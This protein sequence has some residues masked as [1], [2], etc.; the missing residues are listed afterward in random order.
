MLL[1]LE[2][3]EHVV[4]QGKRSCRR[5]TQG[6]GPA[7]RKWLAVDTRPGTV[8][9][10]FETYVQYLK[11]VAVDLHLEKVGGSRFLRG[12]RRRRRDGLGQPHRHGSGLHQGRPDA[13]RPWRRRRIKRATRLRPGGHSVQK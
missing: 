9:D 6:I 12:L 10:L 4:S 8:A 3:G 1:L 11:D 5:H 13:V 2:P 7:A